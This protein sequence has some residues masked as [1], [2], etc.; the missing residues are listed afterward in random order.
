MW[1]AHRV[2]YRISGGSSRG[3]AV[4]PESDSG[5]MTEKGR[6]RT[7]SR[8]ETLEELKARVIDME[9]ETGEALR[10]LMSRL[11]A[12]HKRISFLEMNTT[13]VISAPRPQLRKGRPESDGGSSDVS[14]NDTSE[15]GGEAQ[16]QLPSSHQSV[17]QDG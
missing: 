14:G 1:R 16:Y 13:P 11:G 17:G 6:Q 9:Q 3:P 7:G 12:L 2:R 8:L 10:K 15:P 4:G 5:N